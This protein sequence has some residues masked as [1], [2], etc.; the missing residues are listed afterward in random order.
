MS[1]SALPKASVL[2]RPAGDASEERCSASGPEQSQEPSAS[3]GSAPRED[4]PGDRT[5]ARKNALMVE[6][7]SLGHLPS[8]TLDSNLYYRLRDAKQKN[9]F[10]ASEQEELAD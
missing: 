7:R 3:S 5:V 8:K 1:G 2:R 6:L 10:S 9:L 4:P